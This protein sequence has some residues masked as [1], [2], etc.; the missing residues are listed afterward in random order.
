MSLAE[1]AAG[2]AGAC[3]LLAVLL[4]TTAHRTTAPESQVATPPSRWV[5]ALRGLW[6]A[7]GHTAASGRARRRRALVA[8][9]VGA[10]AWAVTGW[11]AAALGVVA[12]GLWLPWLLGSAREIRARIEMLEALESWCRRMA[13]ILAG[14]GAVGLTQAIAMAADAGGAVRSNEPIAKAVAVLAQRLR[15]GG[16]TGAA[17]TY[18]NG[19]T[20]RAALREFADAIDDR[21]GDTV[22]AALLL[23]LGQQSGG[24]AAVLR[25]LA[26]GVARDVRARR[27]IE[28]ARAEDRQS[29]RLLLVIQ[30]GLLAGLAMVPAFAAPY[31][32][33]VGQAVMA[34]LLSGTGVLLVWMR[35]LALGRPA[36]RFFGARLA[37]AGERP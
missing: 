29:I 7:A 12:T 14:G 2:G 6:G 30:A 23:A 11:P 35:T 19:D 37:G 8:V 16:N 21:A 22:A 5:E 20:R 31:G 34:V 36:P 1:I 27:D 4:T 3:L 13:D 10:A 24:I 18:V 25:Q 17:G 26:D 28:A 32:T 9:A 33:P 15:E